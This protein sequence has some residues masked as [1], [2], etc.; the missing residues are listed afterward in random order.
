MGSAKPNIVLVHWHDTGRYLGAYGLEHVRTPNVDRLAEDGVVFERSF[1]TAPL[2]S[3]SRGSLFTGRYP[4]SNGLMGLAHLG[5]EYHAN[6]HTLPMLL[7]R[8]GYH[9]VLVGLQHESSDPTT[10][11][12][13]E[14]IDLNADRQAAPAVAELAVDRLATLAA[15]D[16]PFLMVVGMFE[17]H[18][19]FPKHRFPTSPD[20]AVDVPPYL[21]QTEEALDDLRGFSAAVTYADAATGRI[22]DRLAALGLDESTIVI[23]TTDH[24]APFPRAKSTLYDAGIETALIVRMPTGTTRP[25]PRTRTLTSHVDVV[26]TLLELVGA[27]VPGNLQGTSFAAELVDGAEGGGPGGPGRE[28]VYAEK[29]WHDV[30]QYDPVRCVRTERYK[31]IVSYEDRPAVPLPGDIARSGSA[32]GVDDAA[33]RPRVELYDLDA[34]PLE[35]DNLA[36]NEALAE[37]EKDLAE[38]LATWQRETGDPALHGPILAARR[39]PTVRPGRV[40]RTALIDP[41]F[42][43][44]G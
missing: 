26:P 13:D 14:V 4:H 19:P 12:Y 18:R 37:V 29:N 38:R 32:I 36:G 31:Y 3:P 20:L 1:A 27:P 11:G 33:P 16:D 25:S 21:A 23:F 35:R 8:H 15:Q 44:R 10:L 5:W 22:L 30:R 6:E 9:S 17:P 39:T 34:D 2:C 41:Q 28:A 7:S 42:V 24:G 43:Q 40:K